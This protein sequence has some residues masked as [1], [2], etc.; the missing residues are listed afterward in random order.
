LP[1]EQQLRH[2]LDERELIVEVVRDPAASWPIASRRCAWW[3][4]SSVRRKSVTSS[5][6]MQMPSGTGLMAR[7]NQRLSPDGNVK[8]VGESLALAG[9]P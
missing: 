5:D 6:R 9:P 2:A 3:S 7:S 4:S 8:L 1:I